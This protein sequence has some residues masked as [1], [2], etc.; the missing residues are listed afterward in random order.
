MMAN[1]TSAINYTLFMIANVYQLHEFISVTNYT[2]FMIV[3]VYQL[4]DIH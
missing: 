1:T 2:L 4:H 3:N